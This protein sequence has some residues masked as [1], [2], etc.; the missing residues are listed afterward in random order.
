[1]KKER[2]VVLCLCVVLSGA[3]HTQWIAWAWQHALHSPTQTAGPIQAGG[4]AGTA[5]N[6]LHFSA[7]SNFATALACAAWPP[8][9]ILYSEA[10]VV[11]KKPKTRP[12]EERPSRQDYS[13][14][15]HYPSV[16]R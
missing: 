3:L 8:L 10:I 6:T 14:A 13:M 16:G 12:G 1:M 4:Q 11:G 9:G 2:I 7:P 5:P 15:A